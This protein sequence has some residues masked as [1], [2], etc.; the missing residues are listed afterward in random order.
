M[1]SC[2]EFGKYVVD[3]I[4]RATL[5]NSLNISNKIDVENGYGFEEL[6]NEIYLS[7]EVLIENKRIDRIAAYKVIVACSDSLKKYRANFNYNKKMI[8]D[9]YII[10]LWEAFNGG[11]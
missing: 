11:N 3:N 7:T 10:K 1:M 5:S 8:I 4:K 9:D 2:K 6:V